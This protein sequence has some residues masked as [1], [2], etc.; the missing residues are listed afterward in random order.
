[1]SS[2]AFEDGQASQSSALNFQPYNQSSLTS[3]SRAA[4]TLSRPD[5]LR[6]F[7]TGSTGSVST[8]MASE[9]TSQ[10]APSTRPGVRAPYLP[11]HLRDDDDDY[12]DPFS[13]SN[14]PS[15][16]AGGYATGSGSVTSPSQDAGRPSAGRRQFNAYGPDGQLQRREADANSVRTR[17][18]ANTATTASGPAGFGIQR[19]PDRGN[20]ARPDMRKKFEHKLTFATSN[21]NIVDTYDSGTDDEI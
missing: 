10:Q 5:T 7:G 4:P 19:R 6:N 13:A 1:M 21:N 9:T 8:V 14:A 18:S 12:H 3:G 15:V 17:S 20:W 16:L 11:P 2:L